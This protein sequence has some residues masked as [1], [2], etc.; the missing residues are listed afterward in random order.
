[1]VP[2]LDRQHAQP[3][4]TPPHISRFPSNSPSSLPLPPPL[5]PPSA[6]PPFSPLPLPIPHIPLQITLPRPPIRHPRRVQRECEIVLRRYL[7]DLLLFARLFHEQ[8]AVGFYPA[9]AGGFLDWAWRARAPMAG[10]VRVRSYRGRRRRRV[11]R[12]AGGGNGGAGVEVVVVVVEGE[13]SRGWKGGD[14]VVAM[15][16]MRVLVGEGEGE[17][18]EGGRVGGRERRAKTRKERRIV[19]MLFLLDTSVE[20]THTVSGTYG[21]ESKRKYRRIVCNAGSWGERA[22]TRSYFSYKPY[23]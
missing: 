18:E 1:M 23:V 14:R 4:K 22:D 15:G 8:R 6:P 13:G 17:G 19:W 9:E 20:R 11:R 21:R 12:L 3:L 16:E 2:L 10:A 7:D 5:P